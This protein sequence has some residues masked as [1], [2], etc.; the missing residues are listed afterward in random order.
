MF[1]KTRTLRLGVHNACARLAP[2]AQAESGRRV[3]LDTTG[4]TRVLDGGVW[5]YVWLCPRN[6]GHRGIV[7]VVATPSLFVEECG[8]EPAC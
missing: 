6:V 5:L 3:G 8:V 2:T 4:M 7:E 1:P